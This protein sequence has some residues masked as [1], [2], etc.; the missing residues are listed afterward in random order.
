[1]AV[2]IVLSA[3]Q[4]A[5]MP[6]PEFVASVH[7]FG[8]VAYRDPHG[9]LSPDGRWLAT[10]A[11][12]ILAVREFPDGAPR[13]LP[14]GNARIRHLAWHPDGRL[15][16]DQFDGQIRWWVYDTDGA[17]REPMFPDR[18]IDTEAGSSLQ[19][20]ALRDLV[21]S[22]DGTKLA[23]VERTD[24]GSTVWML[25]GD[26]EAVSIA[27]STAR[28]SYPAWLPDGRVVCLLLADGKQHVTL[29]CGEQ[30]LS[31]LEGREAFGP[32]GV[33]PDGDELY[34]AIPNDRGFTDL[35]AWNIGQS[36]GRRL[37]SF[38]RDTYAPSVA[39][40]GTVLFKVQDYMTQIAV[41]SATGGTPVIRTAFQAETPSWDPTGTRI[42]V[43]YGTWRR[44]TDDFHYP[45]IA[46]EAGIVDADG[47]SPATE[48]QA[49]V[50]DS[51]SEDQ[52]ITWSPNGQW[53][54]FHSHQQGSDD[55][56]IRPAD[57]A[58]PLRR[59]SYLGRGAEVGWPRWSPDGR[60]IVFNGER[61][62]DGQRA[63][64]WL[65]G[66]DQET[67][68]VT[69][70]FQR[71]NVEGVS[72]E[73]IH[74]EWSGSSDAIVFTTLVEPGTHT[75]YRV[76]REGGRAERL[77]AYESTQRYDGFGASPDGQWVVHVA[78]GDDGVLQLFR[79]DLDDNSSQQ[80]TTDPLEKTQPSV[81]PDGQRIAFTAWRYDARFYVVR[82]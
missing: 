35:W 37:A 58:T 16:V 34:L 71:I 17:T 40:D 68:E 38:A 5:A 55:V 75:F 61:L 54:A 12:H 7:Q 15:L 81:S 82:P 69:Q 50:Q 48:P 56:W 26:A 78:P 14:A 19:A 8:P 29:P 65:I 9:A 67:G 44:L 13:E 53:I 41:V 11:N 49:V 27:T 51:P 80:L 79:V 76:A 59:L 10:A 22:R 21:W 45:D 30:V 20:A 43:T 60:W 3:C 25:E 32:I 39:S 33:S 24:S 72:D 31:G 6:E 70:L 36:S 28:L 62:G 18:V 46:Q 23:A 4:P 1:M 42:G 66:I 47:P 77:Y 73:I 2:V 63:G 74:A 52:G 57:Q 64:M